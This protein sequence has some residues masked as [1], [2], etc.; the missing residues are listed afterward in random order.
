M[1]HTSP[2]C[3][4]PEKPDKISVVFDCAAKC[5][6]ISLN[7]N[8]LPGPNL[9]SSLQ[10]ILLRFSKFPVAFSSDV[11]CMFYQVKVLEKH[12]DLLRFL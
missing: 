10:G 11:E 2:W 6:G 1:V 3:L 8:L 5:N 4:Q 7:D 12:R 9:L